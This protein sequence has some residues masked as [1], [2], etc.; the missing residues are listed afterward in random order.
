MRLTLRTLL[1]YLDEMLVGD[2]AEDIAVKIEESELANEVI[3]RR[4]E[5]M[6]KLQLGAPKPLGEGMGLDPNTVAEYLDNTLPAPHV[7]DYEKVCLESDEHLAETAACHQILSL[8]L[9]DPV[10]TTPR[11]RRR[12][13]A[14]PAELAQPPVSAPEVA[15]ASRVTRVDAAHQATH[16]R[17]REFPSF[18]LAVL[19]ACCFA[20]IGYWWYTDSQQQA[21]RQER[22]TAA[23]P[24]EESKRTQHSELPPTFSAVETPDVPA[25]PQPLEM[26]ASPNGLAN[27]EMRALPSDSIT[28]EPPLA[29]AGGYTIADTEQLG[30]SGFAQLP[31]IS[32]ETYSGDP[33]ANSGGNTAPSQYPRAAAAA[34]DPPTV[35][36]NST[37][38]TESMMPSLPNPHAEMVARG[39]SEGQGLV[40]PTGDKP[41][42]SAVQSVNRAAD[43][44]KAPQFEDL[45]SDL[46]IEPA[47]AEAAIAAVSPAGE[48]DAFV[49]DMINRATR[50]EV[51]PVLPHVQPPYRR[52]ET[53][54]EIGYPSVGS[55]ALLVEEEPLLD[56]API[57]PEAVAPPPPPRW[58]ES[59]VAEIAVQNDELL[60]AVSPGEKPHWVASEASVLRSR[61]V[62]V[63]GFHP[64]WRWGDYFACQ[65]DAGAVVDVGWNDEHGMPTLRLRRGRLEIKTIA[66]NAPY[67]LVDQGGVWG[68]LAWGEESSRLQLFAES[69][70]HA[71]RDPANGD[72]GLELSLAV[73]EGAVTWTDGRTAKVQELAAGGAIAVEAGAAE[74]RS[75][76]VARVTAPLDLERSSFNKR[77]ATLLKRQL[78]SHNDAHTALLTTAADGDPLDAVDAAATLA[79][80]G[81]LKPAWAALANE[82]LNRQ[83]DRVIALL[84][85]RSAEGDDAAVMVAEAAAAVYGKEQGRVLYRML[86]GYSSEHLADGAA[87]L[88]V[89]RLDH[90]LQ[91]ARVLAFWNL[92]EISGATFNYQPHDDP[93]ARRRGIEAWSRTL[94]RGRLNAVSTAAA[95]PEHVLR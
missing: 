41:N 85:Q 50:I 77:R 4:R 78:L 57:P 70:M 51:V 80:C 65:A 40:P 52:L 8:V 33:L 75:L 24:Q 44:N 22:P 23:S 21:A 16:R 86:W 61:L 83:W 31:Y 49:R 53:F 63:P 45:P 20:G 6:R 73:A 3:S 1:A 59:D 84:Q 88:L 92:R 5:V 39:E 95:R 12:L 56:A 81:D 13:Y 2:D 76:D 37:T 67:V 68:V 91:P 35:E 32:T 42:I 29:T 82:K 94:Q 14:V 11:L 58:R 18:E 47:T 79:A 30:P 46:P 7:P 27:A 15:P 25:T 93:A 71:G 9:G 60:L 66:A 19:L 69:R 38:P 89:A 48:V 55:S 72:N 28:I 87:A 62:A 54:A 17:S 34:V 74:S 10:E 36:E 43:L 90:P 26:T 64:R